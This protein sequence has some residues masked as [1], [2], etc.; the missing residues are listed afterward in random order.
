MKQTFLIA[1]TLSFLAGCAEDVNLPHHHP[2]EDPKDYHGVPTD[3]RPPQMLNAP[4]N[5]Q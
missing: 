3:T 1:L 4:G 5:P 2:P